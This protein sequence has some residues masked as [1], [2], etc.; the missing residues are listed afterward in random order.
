MLT[1]SRILNTISNNLANVATPGYKRDELMTS[2]FDERMQIR[3]GDIDKSQR[4]EL[5]DASMLRTFDDL[6]T[7]YEQGSFNQTDRALDFMI[8]GGGFFEIQVNGGEDRVYTRNGSF[9]LDD[10]GRLWLQNVGLVMGTDDNPITLTTDRVHTSSAGNIY[11]DEDNQLLGTIKLVAFNDTDQLIKSRDVEGVFINEDQGNMAEDADSVI[12]DGFLERSNVNMHDCI[13]EMIT[14][15]RA[16]QTAAQIVRMYD[17]EL[18]T[19][20]TEVARIQ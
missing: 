15:Q 8:E 17:E 9:V 2:T 16:F 5:A 1:Q 7:V 11:R 13:A 6:Y 18:N 3:T 19:T 10:E 20:V 12:L 4:I 14:S